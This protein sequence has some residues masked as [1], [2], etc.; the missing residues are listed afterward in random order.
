MVTDGPLSLSTFHP[1]DGAPEG[2][3]ILTVQWFQPVDRNGD[4]VP[5][6]NVLPPK[7]ATPK[8]SDI[9]GK[10]ASGTNQLPDLQLR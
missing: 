6:P 4:F 1:S 5:G 8:T 9:E 7:Y 2:T 3:Y 10:I